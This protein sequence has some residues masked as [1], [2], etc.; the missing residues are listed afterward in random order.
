MEPYSYDDAKRKRRED[1]FGV[2]SLTEN[3]LIANKTGLPIASSLPKDIDEKKIA[4]M[5]ATLLSLS[6]RAI[7][8]TGKGDFDQLYLRGSNGY[9]LVIDARDAFLMKSV[10]KDVRLGQILLDCKRTCEK[11]ASESLGSNEFYEPTTTFP[12]IAPFSSL[13]P[14]F[15]MKKTAV[16]ISKNG[17]PITSIIPKYVNKMIMGLIAPTLLSLS[18]IAVFEMKRGDFDQLYIKGSNGYLLFLQAGPNALLMV[19]ADKDE[20]L[21]L[22]LLDC[23][24]ICEKI[25]QM[26][27]EPELSNNFKCLL[28]G[29]SEVGKTALAH[30]F[31]NGFFTDDYKMTIGLDFHVNTVPINTAKGQIK[32]KLQLWDAGCR[33]RFS[34]LRPKY[35]GGLLGAFLV[36]DLTN[37]SSF[38]HLPLWIEELKARVNKE[39]PILLVGNKSDLTDQRAIPIEKIN[40]F[41]RK[42]NLYYIETSAKKGTGV[43]DCFNILAC[44]MAGIP[45]RLVDID[46]KRYKGDRFPYPY[47]FKPPKPPGDLG[48]ATQLQVKKSVKEEEP[49]VELYCKYCRSKLKKEQKYCKLCGKKVD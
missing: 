41:T 36:F 28:L 37:P 40:K 21:G 34:F 16:V 11:I 24:R 31:S 27:F 14:S 22:I 15:T 44:L 20:R 10:D 43:E 2:I 1:S 46:R 33:A 6:E 13:F 35:Y 7:N 12:Y 32:C 3:T 47:I 30:K 17:M 29:D 45:T 4:A 38:E 25:A 9:L 49:E 5:T 19:L 42:F 23:R 18:E 39:L 8:E 48:V 26:T